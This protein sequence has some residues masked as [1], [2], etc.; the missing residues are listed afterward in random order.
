MVQYFTDQPMP[1]AFTRSRPYRKNDNAHVEQKNWTHVRHLFGY[2]RFEQLDLAP[3]MN[4]LYANEWSLYQNHFCPGV[5]LIDKQ[6]INA[7]YVKRYDQPQTPYQ[8]VMACEQV[9]PEV[10]SSLKALHD[11]FNP[12]I[13]KQQIEVKLRVSEPTDASV[14]FC[15][16]STSL[17]SLSAALSATAST[18]MAEAL[19][20]MTRHWPGLPLDEG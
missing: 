8:R 19:G 18:P 2:D 20:R 7:R 17:P 1:V 16:E 11:S 14:T 4:D 15:Y 6:R 12:F 5:K 3:L 10:K 9:A 13:L